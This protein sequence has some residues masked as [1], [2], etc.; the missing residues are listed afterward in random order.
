MEG[1]LLMTMKE[2]HDA[3]REWDRT[4]PVSKRNIFLACLEVLEKQAREID[5]L[6]EA[7]SNL[8][9]MILKLSGERKTA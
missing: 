7:C 8:Q 1:R 3:I 9:D 5:D 4:G 2:R 6:N